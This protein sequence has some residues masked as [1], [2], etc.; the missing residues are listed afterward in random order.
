MA[1]KR[2]QK[3][4]AKKKSKTVEEI[5]AD[6]Q[7]VMEETLN[8][9][10]RER[11]PKKLSAWIGSSFTEKECEILKDHIRDYYKENPDVKNRDWKQGIMATCLQLANKH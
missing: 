1:N 9:L 4:A 10:H 8:W 7:L 2:K 6:N 11:T 5:R 3:D